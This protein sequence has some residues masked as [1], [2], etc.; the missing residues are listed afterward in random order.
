MKLN[1]KQMDRR[2]KFIPR[3][4]AKPGQSIP[5]QCP[6]DYLQHKLTTVN[7]AG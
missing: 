1:V 2:R 5:N 3:G 4:A 6:G 7:L